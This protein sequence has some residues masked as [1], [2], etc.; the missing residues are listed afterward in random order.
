MQVKLFGYSRN[1]YHFMLFLDPED[2]PEALI[3]PS[4]ISETMFL[5]C[6]VSTFNMIICFGADGTLQISVPAPQHN[7]EASR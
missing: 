6:V 7:N 2:Y 4:L 5:A 1:V 3:K